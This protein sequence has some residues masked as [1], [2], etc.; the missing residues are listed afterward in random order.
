M[1]PALSGKYFGVPDHTKA[2]LQAELEQWIEYKRQSVELEW[3][4]EARLQWKKDQRVAA[5]KAR[6][7]SFQLS[8]AGGV[9]PPEVKDLWV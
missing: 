6:W 5:A 8:E 7:P 4:I 2:R 1:Q 9:L 3:Q